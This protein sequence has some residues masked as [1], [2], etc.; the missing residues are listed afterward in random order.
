ME[1]I[2]G[3]LTG[4]DFKDAPAEEADDEAYGEGHSDPAAGG[5]DGFPF[6]VGMDCQRFFEAAVI[7]MKNVMTR[8]MRRML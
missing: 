4:E 3:A 1:G 6:W 8:A 5:H 7:A 2:G